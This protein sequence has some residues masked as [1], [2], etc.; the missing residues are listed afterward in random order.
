MFQLIVELLC[1]IV[2]LIGVICIFD[3]RNITNRFFSFG[4]QNEGSRGLKI[5]GFVIAVVSGI[6]LIFFE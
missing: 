1:I 4:D 5:L 6:I 2:I 3:A